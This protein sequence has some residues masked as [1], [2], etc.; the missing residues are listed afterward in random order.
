MSI[1]FIRL[2]NDT[3]KLFL[4]QANS[5]SQ[6]SDKMLHVLAEAEAAGTDMFQLWSSIARTNQWADRDAGLT[7]KEGFNPMPKTLANYRS[8]SRRASDLGV[9]HQ[10]SNFADW[11][12]AVSAANKLTKSQEEEETP[13]KSKPID[14][15]EIEAPSYLTHIVEKRRGMTEK[16]IKAFDTLIIRAIEK[17]AEIA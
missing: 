4:A 3:A 16:N 9:G 7:A 1:N 11:R 8:I 6:L 14:L 2:A 12:K 15:N 17:F 10:F 5:M 13:P